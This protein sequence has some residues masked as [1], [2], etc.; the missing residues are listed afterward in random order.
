MQHDRDDGGFQRRP[1]VDGE[2]NRPGHLGLDPVAQAAER[3]IGGENDADAGGQG[4][5]GRVPASARLDDCLDLGAVLDQAVEVA[6]PAIARRRHELHWDRPPQPVVVRGDAAR[7]AQVFAT[8]LDNAAQYTDEGGRIDV[9]LLEGA[10]SAR[11]HVRD[12]G[13]GIAPEQQPTL[14]DLFAPDSPR[15]DMGSSLFSPS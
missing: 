8:L 14:F 7:L 4:V 1:A 9:R 12:T 10:D 11:V 3:P 6:G 5:E 13:V 2:I 15:K